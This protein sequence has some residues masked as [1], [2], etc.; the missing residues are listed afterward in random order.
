MNPLPPSCSEQVG[1][2]R[3]H[4][5]H[6]LPPL[7]L[8]PAAAVRR[9]QQKPGE[10]AGPHAGRQAPADLLGHV[11][12]DRG[13]HAAGQLGQRDVHRDEEEGDAEAVVEAALD[14]QCLTH[15]LGHG[16]VRHDALAERGIGRA[17]HRRQHERAGQR[18]AGEHQ[19]RGAQA[20][21]HR[22]RQ[23]DDQEP[24]GPG[25]VPAQARQV[26]AR[27]VAEQQQHERELAEPL[28]GGGLDVHADEIEHRRSHQH[29]G[30]SEDH[31][32]RHTAG[33]QRPGD[34]AVDHEDHGDGDERDDH[35]RGSRRD[36]LRLIGSASGR[37]RGGC[38][39]S[40]RRPHCGTCW[41]RRR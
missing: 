20:G 13:G 30:R 16:L 8:E 1:Q 22:Q 12:E 40:R 37:R 3:G 28:R 36:R 9:A 21:E 33:V 29:A 41:T 23:A 5:G 2:Q 27:G 15:A 35:G 11:G 24:A 26:D 25:Q 18:D 38:R 7:V 31:R 17:E 14:V 6:D 10:H 34:R 39:W 19:E 32:R 4:E